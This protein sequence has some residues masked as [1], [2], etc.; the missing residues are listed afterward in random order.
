MQDYPN[1]ELIVSDDGTPEFDAIKIEQYIDSN[2]KGNIHSYAVIHHYDNIGTVRNINYAILKSKGSF[3]KIVGGDDSYSSSNVFSEQVK[4]LFDSDDSLVIIGETQ[5]CDYLMKP[6]YDKR[7][8][9]G[10][11]ALNYIFKL[12]YAD[13]RKYILKNDIFPIVTQAM[14]FK[15]IFFDKYGLCDERYILLDDSLT[16]IKVL[17]CAKQVIVSNRICVNHRSNVGISTSKEFFATR[18]LMYYK[19]CAIYAENEIAP[20]QDIFGFIYCYESPR[21]NWFLYYMCLSKNNK[22]PSSKRILISLKYLDALIYYGLSR[23]KK[24]FSRM[25]KRIWGF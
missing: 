14:C 6:I 12:S 24:V 15:R 22:E 4:L 8:E 9:D 19:D 17:R 21:I 7:V 5:Q 18:R 11:K 25:K 13:A 1:V 10:N 23:P 16:A 3:I 20:Y 2:N